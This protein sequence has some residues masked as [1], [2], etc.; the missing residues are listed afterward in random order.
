MT[1]LRGFAVAPT[2]IIAGIARSIGLHVVDTAGTGAD[3]TT[4]SNLM[5]KATLAL[6]AVRSGAYDFGLVHVKATDEASHAG[7]SHAKQGAIRAASAM[8]AAL[9]HAVP[10]GTTI[11]VTGDHTTPCVVRD[12]SSEAVP[13]AMAVKR[14]GAPCDDV[15]RFDESDVARG[16]LGRFRGSSVIELMT[17]LHHAAL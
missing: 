4:H 15:S 13:F 11:A 1:N 12:H 6:R 9:W 16:A 10:T 7:D 5:A 17:A 2:C 8:V 3:G 14:C